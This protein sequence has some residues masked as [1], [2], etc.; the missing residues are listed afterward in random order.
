[1]SR[2][3]GFTGLLAGIG[4]G[5]GIGFILAPKKGSE[6]RKELKNKMDD[7]IEKIKSLDYDNVRNNLVEK[8][9]RLEI[10]LEDL[11]EEK[12]LDIAKKKAEKIKKKA[13]EIYKEA[14]AKGKP[15]I[16]KT[17]SELRDKTVI[18]LKEILKRL[19]PPEKQEIKK[20]NNKKNTSA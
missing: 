3:S 6:T 1:M 12:A 8:I 2:K 17:A 20:I 4:I 14:S 13:N 7:L 10:E 11:D 16:D 18:V 15:I 9:K 19:D 5:L